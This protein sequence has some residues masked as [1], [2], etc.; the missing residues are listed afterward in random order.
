MNADVPDYAAIDERAYGPISIDGP[1]VAGRILDAAQRE[2]RADGITPLQ[3]AAVLHALA[4]YSLQQRMVS[5]AVADL[6]R[7]PLAWQ[8]HPDPPELAHGLGRFFHGIADR[9]EAR[10]WETRP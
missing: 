4:D 8:D 7:R 2:V 1:D 10:E 3:V 9:I 5:D 6:A